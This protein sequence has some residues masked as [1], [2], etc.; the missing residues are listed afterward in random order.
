M[1]KTRTMHHCTSCGASASRWQGRCPGCGEWNTLVEQR[2]VRRSGGSGE[3]GPWG[4]GELGPPVAI[5]EVDTEDRPA[6]PTGLGEV[7]RVLGGGVVPGSVTVLG[8]EPGIGKSTLL[9]Q[10]AASMA[11][12]DQP[13]GPQRVL[14]VSAEESL[15]QVRHRADRLGATV[16]GVWVVSEGSV[17]RVGDLVDELG[18]DLVLV[19]SIQAVSTAESSSAPGS[20][21][22]VRDCA[23]QLVA[24]AR[25]TGVAVVVAGHVTKDGALAGPRV[26]EHVVDTVLAFEGDR[27][28]ELRLLRAV[29]HRFGSTSEVGVMAMGEDGLLPVAD[30][31]GLFLADRRAGVP[32]SA[33]AAVLEGRRPLLVEVQALVSGSPSPSVRRQAQGLD[34]GRLAMLVA[35]LE[36]HVGLC[37]LGRA[38]LH[39]LAVGGVRLSEPGVDLAVALALASAVTDRPLP[40]RLAAFGEVGLTGEVR[41]VGRTADRVAE[42][43]RLGFTQV[44]GPAVARSGADLA[45]PTGGPAVDTGSPGM[46][47]VRTLA[48]ALEAAGVAPGA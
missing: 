3:P 4:G 8:G 26:L 5:T 27:H 22:Q 20:V 34:A 29:K 14:Y 42:A 38:D 6:V 48:E 36:R 18:C 2:V 12:P 43:H 15:A 44:L 19:D 7:D 21:T 9:L 32:G 31:S 28:G 37:D 11:R 24:E 40:P 1:A 47:G 13:G 17:G 30:P 33:V 25:R 45:P 46:T 16:D 10:V 35:V 23:F 39:A 41:G